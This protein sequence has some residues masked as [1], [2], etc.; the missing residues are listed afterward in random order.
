MQ[1]QATT[2]SDDEKQQILRSTAYSLRQVPRTMAKRWSVEELESGIVHHSIEIHNENLGLTS[3]KGT[4]AQTQ[5]EAS[6][7]H[8]YTSTSATIHTYVLG[9]VNVVLP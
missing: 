6:T 2:L 8:Y 7:K 4:H 1:R 5:H 9:L 3:T